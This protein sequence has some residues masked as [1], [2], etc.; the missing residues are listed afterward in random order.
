MVLVLDDLYSD[1]LPLR[2]NKNVSYSHTTANSF[3]SPNE[4]FISVSFKY[5]RPCAIGFVFPPSCFGHSV[6]SHSIVLSWVVNILSLSFAYCAKYEPSVN[7]CF[8]FK[9][10]SLV[11]FPYS[12]FHS[13]VKI[14]GV[15]PFF[16]KASVEVSSCFLVLKKLFEFF[17]VSR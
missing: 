8:I 1:G 10:S 6:N 15:D 16:P 11:R 9:D 12:T 3:I 2:K 7:F 17:C 4:Y 14:F 5:L 13:S